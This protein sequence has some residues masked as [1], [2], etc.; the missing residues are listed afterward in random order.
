MNLTRTILLAMTLAVNGGM[1]AY[2]ATN[3]FEKGSAEES[4]AVAAQAQRRIKSL[5]AGEH[6][7]AWDQAARP[8]QELTPR[9]VFIAGIKS[10]R[11]MVGE[12]KARAILGVGFTKELQDAPPGY[13]AAVVFET[14]FANANGVEEKLVF[15]NQN[16]QWRLAGYFLKKRTAA[17]SGIAK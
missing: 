1:A 10:M 16:G 8:F 7:Q 2:A 6:G 14:N 4:A 15:F 17:S 12:A 11:G 3:V 13:Y 5:D 9:P